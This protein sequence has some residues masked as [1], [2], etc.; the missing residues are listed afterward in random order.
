MNG[1]LNTKVPSKGDTLEADPAAE[2]LER[3]RRL[4]AR[5]G[6]RKTHT[7]SPLD[8][9]GSLLDDVLELTLE[10]VRY[11]GVGVSVPFD[12][13]WRREPA[14]GRA[15]HCS[16]LREVVLGIYAVFSL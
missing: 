5:I 2:Y 7:G 11:A 9:I 8:F 12:N 13:H 3:H 16:A 10:D 1:S 4:P 14:S 15:E 6:P